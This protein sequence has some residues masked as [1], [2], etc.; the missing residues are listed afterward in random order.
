MEMNNIIVDPTYKQW[1][2]DIERRFRQQQIKAVVQVNSCKI[3]FYW[4]LGRDICEMD[5]ERRYGKGVIKALSQDL[6]RNIP[7]VKGL[8]PGGLYYCKRF[9]LLYNKVFEMFPQL[10][11]TSVP[12]LG[13]I[14]KLMHSA[15]SVAQKIE[16]RRG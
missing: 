7:E 6:R 4:S 14:L 3:E 8:T 11:E 13:K 16:I 9:Y 5:V 10:E 15:L 1:G 12:Q 2:V